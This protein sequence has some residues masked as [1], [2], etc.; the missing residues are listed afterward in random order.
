LCATVTVAS[1]FSVAAS[2]RFD[3]SQWASRILKPFISVL[4]FFTNRR[5]SYDGSMRSRRRTYLLEARLRRR[6][7][8]AAFVLIA[9]RWND[10]TV[11]CT[12]DA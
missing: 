3:S 7:F 8:G 10:T 12:A 1:S 9:G 4:Y 11:A 5:K 6:A 2:F